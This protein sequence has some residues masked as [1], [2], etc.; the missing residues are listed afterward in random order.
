[1]GLQRLTARSTIFSPN[2][3]GWKF[4]GKAQFRQSLRNLYI[5]TKLPHEEISWSYGIFRSGCKLIF[6]FSFLKDSEK[7][8]KNFQVLSYEKKTDAWCLKRRNTVI[9]FLGVSFITHLKIFS[10]Y[11]LCDAC[12]FRCTAALKIFREFSVQHRV[13]F[14]T[15]GSFLWSCS[16]QLLCRE[17]VSTCFCEKDVISRIFE[18]LK[19]T[20]G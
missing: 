14:S 17:P 9:R 12:L 5:S 4:C 2:F 20:Q 11:K 7:K 3:L 10:P 6:S 8:W 15:L 18:N 1:M 19:N 16:E 13:Y